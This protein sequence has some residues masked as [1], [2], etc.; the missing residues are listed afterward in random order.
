MSK[1]HKTDFYNIEMAANKFNLNIQYVTMVAMGVITLLNVLDVFIIDDTL[2]F[3]SLGMTMLCTFI[4]TIMFR[5]SKQN[6]KCVKYIKYMILT[7]LVIMITIVGI[8][9][10]YH[11]VMVT[12]LPIICSSQY[13]NKPVIFY[14]FGISVI[15][16]FVSVMAG[17]FF[18]LCDANMLALTTGVTAEYF[19]PATG[20]TTFGEANPN[21]W[22][23]LPIYYAS[24]RIIILFIMMILIIHISNV[25]SENA[26][27]EATFRKLSE[28]DTMTQLYNK[29]KYVQ[30]VK[31][32]YPEVEKVGVIFWDVNG[33][34]IVNDTMGHD[35]G[36]Y[37][38]STVAMSI[39]KFTDETALAYRTGGDEFVMVIENATE[40]RIKEI[41]DGWRSD[42]DMK[43]KGTKVELSSA[44]GYAIGKGEDIEEV[45]KEADANM[46]ADKQASKAMR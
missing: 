36:D 30:M 23:T 4:S 29:N 24:P 43:N 33:L 46:Y 1:K 19:D 42:L 17:Y 16:I 5:L 31:E 18:G 9:L 38:I 11:A 12:V 39:I 22:L 8:S 41:L 26:V 20:M 40:E 37:L 2:M 44:V 27:K 28:T 13:K 34:K 21:P 45:V 3:I 6:E 7:S 35:Y 25:I 14:T 15:G 32:Y 10:T